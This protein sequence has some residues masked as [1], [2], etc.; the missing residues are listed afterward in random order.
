MIAI[1][2]VDVENLYKLRE[3][4][5]YKFIFTAVDLHTGFTWYFPMKNKEATSTIEAFK[6]VLKY[7]LKF[8]PIHLLF[9]IKR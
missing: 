3:N 4:K 9:I 6:Q 8:I 5:P 2:L 7:N 1:D